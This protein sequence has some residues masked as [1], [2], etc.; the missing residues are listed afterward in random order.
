MSDYV[1][2]FATNQQNQ[3]FHPP[4]SSLSSPSL[5]VALPP[6]APAAGT[7]YAFCF[8]ESLSSFLAATSLSSLV[9][10]SEEPTDSLSLSFF[11][12]DLLSSLLGEDL[13]GDDDLGFLVAFPSR[14]LLISTYCRLLGSYGFCT[15]YCCLDGPAS[16]LFILRTWPRPI[17]NVFDLFAL[18]R[19]LPRP[20]SSESE[21]SSYCAAALFEFVT[22]DDAGTFFLDLTAS[23]ALWRSTSCSS[24]HTRG[25]CHILKFLSLAQ[26]IKTCLSS[27]HCIDVIA[28]VC[29]C[30][31]NIGFCCL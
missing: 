21:L 27:C 10:S 15:G 11:S 17:G 16:G 3:S 8:F 5:S 28:E 22:C 7:G 23:G 2:C 1:N 26:V 25:N 19:I 9:S 4:R 18:G 31:T 20:S 14:P 6:A 12:S 24:T 29:A 13:L 30:K